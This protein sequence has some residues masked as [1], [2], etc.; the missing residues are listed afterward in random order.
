MI[1]QRPHTCWDL[2]NQLPHSVD[3]GL[4]ILDRDISPAKKNRDYID[5]YNEA[6]GELKLDSTDFTMI[7]WGL[8]VPIGSDYKPFGIFH[9]GQNRVNEIRDNL[10]FSTFDK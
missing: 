5:I 6:E 3:V 1:E 7:G 4:L 2:R 9:A 10:M 8:S